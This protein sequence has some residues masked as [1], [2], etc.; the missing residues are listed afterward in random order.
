MWQQMTSK[1]TNYKKSIGKWNFFMIPENGIANK[2]SEHTVF[3]MASGKMIMLNEA[4]L[5]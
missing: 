3:Q 1:V 5:Q 4:L 2:P